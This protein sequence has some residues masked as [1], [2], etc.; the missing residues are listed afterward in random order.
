MNL[1]HCVQNFDYGTLKYYVDHM[2]DLSVGRSTV[3]KG[4]LEKQGVNL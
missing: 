1:V 4:I 3:S 2:K